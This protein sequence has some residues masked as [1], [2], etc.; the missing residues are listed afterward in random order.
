MADGRSRKA[1]ATKKAAAVRA[2]ASRDTGGKRA[3]Q[4]IDEVRSKSYNPEVKMGI[5]DPG[6]THG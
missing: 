5:A 6:T 1:A 4:R 3:A 2:R